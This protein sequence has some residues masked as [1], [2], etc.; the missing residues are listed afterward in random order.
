[1]FKNFDIAV[2]TKTVVRNRAI[3]VN[4]NDLQTIKFSITITQSGE[5]VYLT[6]STVRLAVKKPDKKTVL[7][8]CT[9]I[10]AANGKCEIILDT[11]AYIVHGLHH[12]EVMI[13]YAAD[14]VSVTGRFSYT[15]NKGILDEGTFESTN[16]FQS[17]TKTIAGI[18]VD[19]KD[20]GTEIDD[21]AQSDLEAKGI[22]LADIAKKNEVSITDFESEKVG[23]D[24]YPA[25][26]AALTSI[27]NTGSIKFPGKVTYSMYSPLVLP[28]TGHRIRIFS[29]DGA[30]ILV[31]H[32]GDGIVLNAQNEN[33]SA[34]IIEGLG[35]QGT[36]T[37]YPS[38]GYIPPSTGAGIRLNSAYY[39]T[40]RD[41]RVSGFQ[42]GI[43]LKLAI[44]NNFEGNTYIRHNQYGIYFDGG[45]TNVNNFNGIGIREN[46]KAGVY[47]NVGH[48][49]F[50]THN[51]FTDCLI[52][53]NIP[54]PYNTG[55][56]APN[57][58]IGVYLGGAYYNIFDNCYFENQQYAVYLTGSS[59]G[60]KFSKCRFSP[61]ADLTRLDKVMFDGSGVS[62]NTFTECFSLSQDI[63]S[64]NVESNNASQFY[65][66]FVNCEGF[67]F[68]PASILAPIDVFNL[69]P[70]Q[71][72]WG[73]PFGALIIPS[74][75]YYN[76]PGEGATRGRITGIGSAN[77]TLNADGYGELMLGSLITAATTITN[78]TNLK[79]GQYF[80]LSNYQIRFPVT[81]KS[82]TDGINGLVLKNL[83][84]A[85]LFRY[86]DTI[87]FYVTQLGKI[88]EVGRNFNEGVINLVSS[89]PSYIGQLAIVDGVGY[90]A[91]G[92]SSSSDWK[93]ITN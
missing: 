59:D 89:S 66:Q 73:T 75:G 32:N 37:S 10:D 62:N 4:T 21:Q 47:F 48:S 39:C 60:N 35:I 53:S 40:L 2:D 85:I 9:I 12:A 6:G 92:T 20:K 36:N 56:N 57:D 24:W 45:A 52:E 31:K 29:N 68:I 58:S 87:L 16:E 51:T 77:A 14:K 81:L 64:A 84:D 17:N 33:Y 15:A 23:D 19:L 50:P 74:H 63:T 7:Q 61:S 71:A 88:V 91:V 78:I 5:P 38:D 54:F 43:H 27:G 25:F 28:L 70:N 46:R 65:N 41:V 11:Q 69:R 90:I 26:Q 79:K 80:T 8:D 49:P 82:S 13:Y 1:M 76:N 86:S 42:Y 18:V 30:T 3:T 67:T 34:H 22:Q 55:G 93:Q 83:R 72:G 44:K